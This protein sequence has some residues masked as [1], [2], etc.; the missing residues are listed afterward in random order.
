MG[1]R[2]AG[3]AIF[4]RRN[5]TNLF[6]D[7]DSELS[8]ADHLKYHDGTNR[9][10][11]VCTSGSL[12]ANDLAKEHYLLHDEQDYQS[13]EYWMFKQQLDDKNAVNDFLITHKLA[14]HFAAEMSRSLK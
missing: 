12:I 9:V 1:Q 4:F 2:P 10:C 11:P 3:D 5:C 14:E 8:Q 13:P 7:F 6:E